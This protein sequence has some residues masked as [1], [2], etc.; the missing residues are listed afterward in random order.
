MIGVAGPVRLRE[1]QPCMSLTTLRLL[2][3]GLFANQRDQTAS[4]GPSS[5]PPHGHLAQ[6]ENAWLG[7]VPL[8][9]VQI[10]T[11]ICL[12]TTV[13]HRA[14]WALKGWLVARPR[15]LAGR[16]GRLR[17]PRDCQPVVAHGLPPDELE[18]QV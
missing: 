16:C 5:R 4:Q 11:D 8:S 12:T 1:K 2:T 15:E 9:P 6:D 10:A 17:Q 3:S 14:C 18:S 13:V 7:S